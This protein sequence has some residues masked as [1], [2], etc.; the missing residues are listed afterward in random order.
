[1]RS[2]VPEQSPLRPPAGCTRWRDPFSR[3]PRGYRVAPTSGFG[4]KIEKG[5]KT[6]TCR[7]PKTIPRSER[8]IFPLS[9]APNAEPNGPPNTKMAAQ[10]ERSAA[11][12]LDVRPFRKSPESPLGPGF[13]SHPLP[14][15]WAARFPRN[16]G[17]CPGGGHVGI[18]AC[19]NSPTFQ[20]R[21]RPIPAPGVPRC[22]HK[23]A[24]QTV[25]SDLYR[26]FTSPSDT[27][28]LGPPAPPVLPATMQQY[29]PRASIGRISATARP[30]RSVLD[31]IRRG[32]NNLC[33]SALSS[34][35]P[36]LLL[37]ARGGLSLRNAPFKPLRTTPSILV[38][39]NTVF[40][41]AREHC[42]RPATTIVLPSPKLRSTA[43]FR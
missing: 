14:S 16:Q 2:K 19:K 41:G 7:A 35:R 10:A 4:G 23:A 28:L 36:R 42:L 38:S 18:T 43:R 5:G 17:V 22:P 37:R 1:M 30:I 9:H 13:D 32:K 11:R 15:L 29:W 26:I 31:S 21:A 39:Q 33:P 27:G 6:P 8:A 12:R 34:R 25:H 3:G 40:P 20:P 24:R